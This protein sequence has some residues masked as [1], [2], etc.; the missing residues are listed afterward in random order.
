MDKIQLEGSKLEREF[1]IKTL[2]INIWACK[3]A[4]DDDGNV[5]GIYDNT[6]SRDQLAKDA[7]L[8]GVECKSDDVI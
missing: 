5:I 6:K 8:Y 1:D 7:I 3:N 2:E 4:L